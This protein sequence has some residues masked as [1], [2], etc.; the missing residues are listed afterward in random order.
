MALEFNLKSNFFIPS[1]SNKKENSKELSFITEI[2]RGDKQF[3]WANE[4][5]NDSWFAGYNK[6][7]E[8]KTKKVI[9]KEKYQFQSGDIIT[10]YFWNKGRRTFYFSDFETSLISYTK[11]DSLN[12]SK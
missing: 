11:C 2:N 6:W 10:F 3:Y 12:N 5:L 7:F 8:F 1:I 9:Q 4:N